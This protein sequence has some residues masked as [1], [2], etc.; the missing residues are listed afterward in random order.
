MPNPTEATEHLNTEREAFVE[1]VTHAEITEFGSLRK[2]PIMQDLLRNVVQHEGSIYL[3]TSKTES[4]INVLKQSESL[5]FTKLPDQP[6]ERWNQQ[7]EKAKENDPKSSVRWIHALKR[8][9]LN[10]LD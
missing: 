1:K 5:S 3:K 4:W 6:A 10:K 2:E 9:Y 7:L 8:F